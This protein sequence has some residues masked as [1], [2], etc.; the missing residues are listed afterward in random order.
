MPIQEFLFALLF[1]VVFSGCGAIGLPVV[2][3][4][5]S[6]KPLA[7]VSAKPI[8]LAL[9]GYCVWILSFLRI[10]NYQNR[11]FIIVVF[12]AAILIGAFLSRN[13]FRVHHN[14]RNPLRLVLFLE[15]VTLCVYFLYLFV[16][17]YNSALNGTER[18][19]DISLLAAAGKT[20]FFPFEDTWYAGH[21]VNYYYYGS[22]LMSLIS[23]LSHIRYVLSYNL[24]LGLLYCQSVILSGLLVYALTKSKYLTLCAAFLVTTAGTL[25]FAVHTGI[26]AFGHTPSLYSYASSTRLYSPSYIINEIPSYSFTV[27]DLHAHVLGLMFFLLNLILLYAITQEHKPKIGIFVLLALILATSGMTNTWD[28]ITLSAVLAIVVLIKI[29]QHIRTGAG[30]WFVRCI[31]TIVIAVVL[32]APSIQGFQSPIIGVRRIAP[33]VARHNLH[34]VQYPTPGGALLGIWGMF[35]IGAL[36][37]LIVKRKELFNHIFTLAIT[38]VSFG[39]IIGVEIFFIADI[40]SIANLPFFRANTTFKFGYG[41]WVM[42]SVAFATWMATYIQR[43]PA[44]KYRPAVILA[45]SMILIS[46]VGGLVYP[47]QAVNQ[48][49]LSNQQPLSLDG[50]AWMKHSLPEDWETIEYI[51]N[52]ITHRVVIAEAVGDSYSTFSRIATFTGM[53]TPMGWKT[54]EWTWRFQ[55]KKAENAPVGQQE[56]TGWSAIASVA[57]AIQR[58]YET[59]DT[60]EAKD[61]IR[62]YAIKYIFVGDLERTIYT[63]LK[64]QK[65]YALARPIFQTGSSTLFEIKRD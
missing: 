27:G 4:Y 44:Q 28:F 43:E 47:Y 48:F 31:A 24:A 26:A 1:Y 11:I 22:Y 41:A 35:V 45:H 19:M 13:F 2:Q 32:M 46:V 63:N 54:H 14:N 12:S 21:A 58:L 7:Y 10:F 20:N 23:N 40:Y 16:R 34:D 36:W 62:T 64:E 65:F 61:I 33:F 53:I 55:G 9:F 59:E 17:S 56:E 50:S 57:A 49:Y 37:I 5:I 52:T 60:A 42:L 51:N 3:R 8:G 38:V 30:V 25:F 6:N 29:I 15:G 39:I 18:F